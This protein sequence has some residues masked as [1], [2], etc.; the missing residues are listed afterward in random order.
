M[1]MAP[2]EEPWQWPIEWKIRESVFSSGRNV[3]YNWGPI[4]SWRLVPEF[5]DELSWTLTFWAGL[6]VANH[7][8]IYMSLD[9]RV[10]GGDTI[11][12]VDA[13]LT[14]SVIGHPRMTRSVPRCTFAPGSWPY[15]YGLK[16]WF[17]HATRSKLFVNGCLQIKAIIT[18]YAIVKKL[19]LPQ[20]MERDRRALS[21][22]RVSGL[23]YAARYYGDFIIRVHG[24]PIHVHKEVLRNTW[25]WFEP[26]LANDTHESRRNELC[27]ECHEFYTIRL[28]LEYVYCK[29]VQERYP[30]PCATEAPCF[31][32]SDHVSPRFMPCVI[33]LFHA[34]NM[35]MLFELAELCLQFLLDNV[36]LTNVIL[37]LSFALQSK[38]L[39]MYCV[40]YYSMFDALIAKCQTCY[41]LQEKYRSKMLVNQLPGYRSMCA[42]E[43]PQIRGEIHRALYAAKTEANRSPLSLG[44]EMSP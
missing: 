41:Y 1:A 9:E 28:L 17:N 13:S 12:S 36:H 24:W 42:A 37:L 44:L 4:C 33:A 32:I 35:Y 2:G 26:L 38:M 34:A 29:H 8:D 43:K 7:N 21:S 25:A 40:E 10:D 20:L 16:E 30:A 14:V 19:T 22:A 39:K 5:C 6:T 27:I 15:D 3:P 18:H 23:M 11:A 31:A